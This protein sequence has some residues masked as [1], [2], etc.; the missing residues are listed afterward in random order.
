MPDFTLWGVL[1]VFVFGFA[2]GAGWSIAAWLCAR[3]LH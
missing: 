3:V 2:A 1:I